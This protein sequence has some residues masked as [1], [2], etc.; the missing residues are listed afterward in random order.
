MTGL[1]KAVWSR[2]MILASGARGPGFKSRNGPFCLSLIMEK[3]KS[4]ENKRYPLK[5]VELSL[6]RHNRKKGPNILKWN[7]TP[8]AHRNHYHNQTLNLNAFKRLRFTPNTTK[9]KREKSPCIY[10]MTANYCQ[11]FEDLLSYNAFRKSSQ[12]DRFLENQ[13][14]YVKSFYSRK[15]A[16]NRY[17]E[18][19]EFQKAFS[20]KCDISIL[21][22]KKIS[23]SPIT[24]PKTTH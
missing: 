12:P 2:G 9:K 6:Q 24:R 8:K 1:R 16:A 5:T 10:N 7:L 17:L 4:P 15:R 14:N 13:S 21:I 3:T 18:T 11:T 20:K 22:G 19:E 23:Y